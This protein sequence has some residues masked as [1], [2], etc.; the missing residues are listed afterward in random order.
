MADNDTT[1]DKAAEAQAPEAA[2]ED[3][4]QEP[5]QA[6][7]P[8]PQWSPRPERPTAE[9]VL[10]EVAWLM[11]QSKAHQGFQL[12]DLNW[13]AIP[14]IRLGQFRLFLGTPGDSQGQQPAPPG[15]LPMGVAFWAMMSKEVERRFMTAVEAGTGPVALKPADWN[16]G[17]RLW[18]VDLIAPF[19]SPENKQIGMMMDDFIRNGPGRAYIRAKDHK[20][21]FYQKD[22]KTGKRQIAE[23]TAQFKNEAGEPIDPATLLQG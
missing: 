5:Q 22:L 12:A 17:N 9:H 8:Q 13:F 16:S 2:A 18:M 10:G 15:E 23:F 3:A 14:P 1:E 7:Q 11:S 21:K 4:G 6:A 20:L 19:A